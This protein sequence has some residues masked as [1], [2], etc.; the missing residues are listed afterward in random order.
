LSSAQLGLIVNH[1]QKKE[2]VMRKRIKPSDVVR[3]FIFCLLIV[4]LL[5]VL[6]GP[7]TA[8]DDAEEVAL[9]NNAL[10][11]FD[12]FMADKDMGYLK[13][14]LKDCEGILIFPSVV[15]GGFVFG[16]SGGHGVLLVRDA[17]TSEWSQPVFYTMGAVSFG[18]LAGVQKSQVILLVRTERG[19]ESL[20]T[21]SF[22]LGADVSIAT[23]PVGIG[24]SAKGVTADM[25][26]FAISQGVYGGLSLDGSVIGTK[27]AANN[28]YYDEPVRPVD[29]IVAHSV[30]N[31]QSDKLRDAV[32]KAEES[33]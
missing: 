19:L 10:A 16:G 9:V 7:A 2:K 26:S 1:Y 12:Q 4:G 33:K 22:K 11:T 6:A 18:L 25:L 21:S 17:K 15:K 29:I 20:Y 14:H 32:E 31:P 24:A 27:D 28:A 3:N 30:K 23:G 13:A 8:A 5:A